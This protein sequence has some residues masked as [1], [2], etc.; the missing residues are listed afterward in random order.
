MA[1]YDAE[2][3]GKRI[4]EL[5][6]SRYWTQAYLAEKIN[7]SDKTIS[8]WEAGKGTPSID[9]F[10]VLAKVFGVN[11]DY[12]M[13]GKYCVPEAEDTN[14]SVDSGEFFSHEL[15]TQFINNLSETQKHDIY[16][17]AIDKKWMKS[18]EEI[19]ALQRDYFDISPRNEE[20]YSTLPK[21]EY[22][23]CEACIRMEIV[24]R[25]KYHYQGTMAEMINKHFKEC[26]PPAIK[27]DL[28][29]MYYRFVDKTH[30]PRPTI[31]GAQI[32]RCIDY[33]CTL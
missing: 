16:N 12:L 20:H 17:Y 26:D 3:I 7:V 13:L 23:F 4:A 24:F 22:R 15:F 5:R 8:K 31:T 2:H 14:E 27:K 6:R 9:N 11:I 1:V 21:H 33:I 29:A 32:V 30:M 18:K 19:L 10:P 25:D 28:K